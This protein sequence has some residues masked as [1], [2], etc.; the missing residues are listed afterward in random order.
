MGHKGEG[1]RDSLVPTDTVL[2]AVDLDKQD[3]WVAE[4][5]MRDQ[6]AVVLDKPRDKLTSSE[7]VLGRT[8]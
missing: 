4:L 8:L 6:W 5:D 7:L 2:K 1:H 3:W